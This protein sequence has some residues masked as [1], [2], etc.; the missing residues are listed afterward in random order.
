MFSW[1]SGGQVGE[2]G[3]GQPESKRPSSHERKHLPAS[4][5]AVRGSR[6]HQKDARS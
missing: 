4:T 5:G 2:G 6:P 1:H 3:K